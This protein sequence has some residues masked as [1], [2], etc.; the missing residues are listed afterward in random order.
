MVVVNS[1]FTQKV[2]FESFP[3]LKIK[4]KVLYP[5]VDIYAMEEHLKKVDSSLD[6][7]R[8]K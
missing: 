3:S 6:N 1:K 5:V 7:I 4:P 8:T 2:F